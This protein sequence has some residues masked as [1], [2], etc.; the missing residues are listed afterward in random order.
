MKTYT[1][2]Y[3]SWLSQL[4]YYIITSLPVEDWLQTYHDLNKEYWWEYYDMGLSA[5]DAVKVFA[6]WRG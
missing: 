5:R 4:Y 2:H 3:E 6:G 1:T